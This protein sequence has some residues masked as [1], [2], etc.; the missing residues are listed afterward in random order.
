[1]GVKELSDKGPEG[2]RLG[3]AAA[4]LVGFYGAT[5]VDQPASA[6]QSAV[7]SAALTTITDIVTTASMTAAINAMVARVNALS[8]LAY[9]TRA[10]LVEIG[11]QKGAA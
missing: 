1:M 7:A 8:I 6:N 5:P 11:L 4:D 3:Q 10:D 2:T 9:Q